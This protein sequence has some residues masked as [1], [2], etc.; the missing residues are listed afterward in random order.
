VR[1]RPNRAARVTRATTVDPPEQIENDDDEKD[2][3]KHRASLNEPLVPFTQ[4]GSF[5]WAHAFSR[6]GREA[7]VRTEPLPTALERRSMLRA[8][9][10]VVVVVVVLDLF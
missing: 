6:V 5:V 3:S 10:L 1:L 7:P 9:L 2:C 8:I 4:S